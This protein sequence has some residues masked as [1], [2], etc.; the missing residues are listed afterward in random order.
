MSDSSRSKGTP[1]DP[2]LGAV[3]LFTLEAHS[4]PKSVNGQHR[5]LTSGPG[6]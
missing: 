6:L 4:G 1:S 5:P 2:T 3:Q